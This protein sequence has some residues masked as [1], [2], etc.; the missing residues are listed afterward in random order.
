MIVDSYVFM[1]GSWNFDNRSMKHDNEYAFPI[2]DATIAKAG[3][4]I[5]EGD[6][7]L[8]GMKQI[9]LQWYKENFSFWNRVFRRVSLLIKGI[10]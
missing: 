2:Y 1:P 4:E 6:L 5:F 7:K 10:L 3:L 8:P 9:D